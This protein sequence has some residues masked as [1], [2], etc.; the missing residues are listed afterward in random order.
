MRARS[1][2]TY[3]EAYMMVRRAPCACL[4]QVSS[5]PKL[6]SRP[7]NRRSWYHAYIFGVR[8]EHVNV[9]V[10]TAQTETATTT[11]SAAKKSVHARAKAP[12]SKPAIHVV[13][14]GK[15]DA[16]R[17][18]QKRTSAKAEIKAIE[19]RVKAEEKAEAKAAASEAKVAVEPPAKSMVESHDDK[20][21][22]KSTK[23]EADKQAPEKQAPISRKKQAKLERAAE[24]REMKEELAAEKKAEKEE[25]VAERKAAR[26]EKRAA[27][28]YR[29]HQI[30]IGSAVTVLVL[31]LA[32]VLIYPVAQGYYMQ[33]RTNDRL[34]AEYEALENRN[35]QI[36]SNIDNLQTDAGIEDQAREYGW[37]RSDE[38]AVNVVNSGA[39]TSQTALPEPIESDDIAAPDTWVTVLLDPVFGVDF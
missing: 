7:D 24:K 13:E 1:T 5:N 14:G 37:I 30:M 25:R 33:E 39:T 12:A 36:Q 8:T 22:A 20:P 34:Q 23:T 17:K 2:D 26:A 15:S 29:R 35:A 31:V 18:P 27:N 10:N 38:N 3:L 32:G 16:A 21:A 19:K 11:Q 9:H 6:F 28:A 4:R